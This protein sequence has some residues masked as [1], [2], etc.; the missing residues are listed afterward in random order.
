MMSRTTT[1]D[2]QTGQNMSAPA[3][4]NF[5]DQDM[6]THWT[7]MAV[8][9]REDTRYSLLPEQ[10]MLPSILREK[11][12]TLSEKMRLGDNASP[13]SSIGVSP[14][15]PRMTVTWSPET[16]HL[17]DVGETS[18]PNSLFLHTDSQATLLSVGGNSSLQM[19]V[20]VTDE[21]KNLLE[22]AEKGDP[23]RVKNVLRRGSVDPD[24]KRNAT[25]R[26]ALER[27]CGYGQVNVVKELIEAGADPEQCNA[28]GRTL[29]H[30]ACTGGHVDIV[31]LLID[32]TRDID[33][34]D[35]AGRSAAHLA[36]FNGEAACLA[37]LADKGADLNL[38]DNAG[39]T[40]A[41]LAAER[42]HPKVLEHLT[43][44]G[45]DLELKDEV[46]KR[47]AHYAAIHGGL[48]CLIFLVQIDCDMTKTDNAGLVPAH[49][50]AGN[51]HIECLRYL[52]KAGTPLD[53]KD[54]S[55]KTLAHAAAHHGAMTCLHWLF[56]KGANARLKDDQGN[57]PLHMAAVGGHAKCFNCC[58]QH[59]G[60]L[61]ITNSR[62]EIAMETARRF[63]HPV[64]IDKAVKNEIQ[65]LHCVDKFDVLQWEKNHQPTRVQKSLNDRKQVI[66]RS[67]VPAANMPPIDDL[68][69]TEKEPSRLELNKA[70]R[71]RILQKQGKGDNLP[72]D[73]NLPRRDLAARYFGDP[74]E[75]MW[76][77]K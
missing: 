63:G 33:S 73:S 42:N 51:D 77:T 28:T 48:E 5:G 6:I 53:I 71:E 44:R 20:S 35:R 66:Y 59:N 45:V 24:F 30:Q 1:M 14:E 67:P 54:K 68:V 69:F 49:C 29:L 38:E 37:V 41:H 9:E 2:K 15:K 22:A 13:S 18:Y 39:K 21:T 60:S 19:N 31:R 58:L 23:A 17:K 3:G 50:A 43:E 4:G 55:S 12:M 72:T 11:S 47:P 62:N 34:V 64:I 70:K 76:L 52:I 61:E 10:S 36:A 56:E 16:K 8:S 57:T 25:S 40:P 32:Y 7:S 26:T 46:G 74:V 27:A 65:C 75:T